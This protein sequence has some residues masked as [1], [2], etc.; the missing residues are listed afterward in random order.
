M[1]RR[2]GLGKNNHL[3]YASLA[4]N[5]RY[6][7]GTS[8]EYPQHICFCGEIRKVLILLGWKKKTQHV[9]KSY[10][11]PNNPKGDRRVWAN[12]VHPDMTVQN[13]VSDQDLHCLPLIQH[14]FKHIS[15]WWSRLFFLQILGQVWYRV[16]PCPAEPGY[17]LPCKQCRTRS[18]GFWRSQLIWICT[19]CH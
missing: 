15:R 12:S 16:N 5:P 1:V 11:Y 8:D 7:V 6:V 18:V 13:A 4:L 9:I 14:P 2:L 3:T 19:V 17:T 10:V